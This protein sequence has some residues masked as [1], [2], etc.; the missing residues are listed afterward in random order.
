M[1]LNLLPL[2]FLLVFMVFLPNK[3]GGGPDVPVIARVASRSRVQVGGKDWAR[4]QG[5]E[6]WPCYLC[7]FGEMTESPW[8]SVEHT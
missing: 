1:I 2:V 8:D 7:D 5:L 4:S 6:F 3:A